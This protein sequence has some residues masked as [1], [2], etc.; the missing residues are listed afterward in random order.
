MIFTENN[1]QY[2]PRLSSYE[3][4]SII[5]FFASITF[6][7]LI[8]LFAKGVF[9]PPVRSY[10][11][12][13]AVAFIETGNYEAALEELKY[14][15]YQEL[16]EYKDASELYHI[17][18]SHKYYDEGKFEEA[19]DDYYIGDKMIQYQNPEVISRE[20]EYGEK[21]KKEYESS[22]RAEIQKIREGIPYVGMAE[23][24]IDITSLGRSSA[25]ERFLKT[26]IEYYDKEK[27]KTLKY[28]GE[29]YYYYFRSGGRIV[30]VAQCFK[31][32]VQR[33]WDERDGKK[34]WNTPYPT[35]PAYTTKRRVSTTAKKYDSDVDEFGDAE[36]YYDWYYDDFYDF[37]D[38]EE[39]FNEYY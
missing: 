5:F 19:L 18:S 6:T 26:N 31:G 17:C 20:K 38:A 34:N 25:K 12:K 3:R 23:E 36:D 35:E 16:F 1:N 30:F 14:F 37:E 7:T 24:Y 13:N 29:V 9:R 10:H 11:Y 2:K 22:S 39:Y 4:F 15:D 32:E 28:Y 33:V 27:R 21:I 8:V